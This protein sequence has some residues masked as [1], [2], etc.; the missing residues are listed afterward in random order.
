LRRERPTIVAGLARRFGDLDLAE[1]C[2][3]DAVAEALEHWAREGEPA[4]PAGWL[5]TTARRKALDRLR[6]QRVGDQKLAL[7]AATAEEAHTEP[8]D[9]RLA[10]VFACCHPAIPRDQQVGL[11][12]R[13][14]CALTT[15][16]IAAAFLVSEPAM[17][18][19]L[20]RAKRTLRA[21]AV[22]FRVPDPDDMGERLPE[23]L[24]VIYLVFNEGWLASSARVPE[25]E[26]LVRESVALADLLVGLMPHEPEVLALRALIAF[27]QSRAATRF[28]S[29]GRLVLLSEQDRSRWDRAAIRYGATLLDRA[30][31]AGRPGPYQ[32]QAAIAALH[33]GAPS[34]ELTDWRQIRLLYSRL[35]EMAPSPVVR[36]NRAVATRYVVG[37]EVALAEVDREADALAGY[38]LFH[39]TRAA[40]LRDLGRLDEARTADERAYELAVN[41]AE[42]ELLA[43]RLA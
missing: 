29:W 9:D 22:R 42:R 36:L 34:W 25:R 39:S 28:A 37:A 15:G 5:V 16:E 17:A 38:R 13:S 8:D 18:Q 33:A 7:L 40:L 41:P 32:I 4:N 20:V 21:G 14:V 23:V 30:L 43:T 31:A 1:D 10:L 24:S 35:D 19:R 27:H 3:Q 26:D 12:L 11:T 6:R 2:V